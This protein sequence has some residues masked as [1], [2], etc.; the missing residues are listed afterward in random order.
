MKTLAE[1]LVWARA[2]VSAAQGSE[3]T[4]QDLATKAGVTQ[5]AI[6][7]LES[8]RTKTSRSITSIA[9]ALGVNPMWLAEGKGHPS[10]PNL[11]TPKA[12]SL[13]NNTEINQLRKRNLKALINGRLGGDASKLSDQIEEDLTVVQCWL[14]DD[15]ITNETFIPDRIARTVETLYD[16]MP[17][18]LDLPEEQS[19]WIPGAS[20]V[21]IA[22]PDH[23]QFYQV[24]KVKL[25]LRA[26][27]TGFQTVPD[28]YDGDTVSLQ[29]NWV[30][31]KKLNP[32]SLLALT[33]AGE[34]MEPNLYEGDVVIIDTSDRT[35][36]DGAVYAFNYEGEAVIKRLVK[37][38]G[39]WWLFSD[40]V[41]QAKHRPKGCRSGECVIVG[42]VV[43]RET[44]HI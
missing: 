20:R 29:K 22:E 23:P 6:G 27:V 16:L 44:D 14:L 25:Q 10:L 39:E 1:R 13:G 4:Q 18:E 24:K 41:D 37:E 26:G 7:H 34:S 2:Q 42:R 35:M 36:K 38:R 17:G 8:G 40:N 21:V 9:L 43:K 33:V 30:D 11:T 32:S 28:I 31:R 19:T 3:F 5:G 12:A 15:G